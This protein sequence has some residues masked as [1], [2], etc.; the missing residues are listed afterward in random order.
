MKAAVVSETGEV[1]AYREFDEPVPRDGE[2]RVTV[3]ACA[4][5]N[6]TKVRAAGRHFSFNA[7]P[8]FVVGI[9]GVGKLEDGRRVYFLFPRPPFGGMAEKTVVPSSQCVALSEEVDDIT[10]AA[11]ADPGMSAWVALQSRAKLAPGETV[12]VN[13]ATG[14]AGRIAVQVAK[15]LGAGRVIATGRNPGVL[16]S[17]AALGADEVIAL[18]G[19]SE[20]LLDALR[21]QF[22]HGVDVV[23]D[24]L[25][26]P[27]AEQILAAA[28]AA[29]GKNAIRFVQIGTASA[30]DITLPG[31]VLRSS[32]LQIMGSGIGTVTIDEIMGIMSNLMNAAPAAR[33]EI[34]KKVLPLSR[35]AEAWSTESMT[36]RYVVTMNE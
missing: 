16:A 21:Q 10:L 27:S 28:R 35:I 13:G 32:P 33:F 1:P 14:S 34:A 2:V 22:E 9:D 25:W 24:Y 8:P 19:D 26:G 3:T 6:F 30:S 15:Y 11:I 36:P 31:T 29:T 17:F 4:L 18:T 7:R 20:P 23:L 12:L 5:T